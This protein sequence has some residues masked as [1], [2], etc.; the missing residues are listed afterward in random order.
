M[1][2]LIQNK[3]ARFDYEILE[4]I[5]A[6]MELF[7]FE[8]K[9]LKI[10]RGSITGARVLIR[11]GRTGGDEAFVVGMDIPAFQPKNTPKTYEKDRT[12]RL[13]L[14][15]KEIA[16]LSGSTSQKGLTIIPLSVYTKHGLIKMNIGLARGRKKYDKRELIKK[17]ETERS[18]R[19]DL[20]V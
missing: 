16:R 12:R 11:P 4:T 1:P 15:K 7:G 8:V 20:R 19:R 9:S 3:K 6:G 5:E 13:L 17:R 14:K 18:V 2:V 10:K